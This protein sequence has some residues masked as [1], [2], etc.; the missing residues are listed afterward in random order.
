MDDFFNQQQMM[1]HAN[2][3]YFHHEQIRQM[4]EQQRLMD[5]A[6]Q[7]QRASEADL[8]RRRIRIRRNAVTRTEIPEEEEEQILM[9]RISREDWEWRHR[10]EMR[11][12]NPDYQTGEIRPVREEIPVQEQ[13][14]KLLILGLIS[15]I[16]IVGIVTGF[17]F[18]FL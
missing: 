18:L 5:E 11:Q 7:R 17:V 2:H 6:F 4:Q 12:G 14:K 9:P 16:I 3:M 1:Q 8:E 15:I 10:M 13:R